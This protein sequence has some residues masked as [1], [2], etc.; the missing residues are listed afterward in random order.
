MLTSVAFEVC[1]LRVEVSPWLIVLGLAD[2]E[3]VGA[4]GGGGGGGGGGAAFLWQAPMKMMV[5][6]TNISAL[7]FFM[8]ELD[9]IAWFT[10]SSC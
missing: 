9:A 3:A 7:H 6:R 5:A 1:Q 8:F 4:A 2:S 10:D